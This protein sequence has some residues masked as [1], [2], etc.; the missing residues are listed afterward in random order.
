MQKYSLQFEKPAVLEVLTHDNRYTKVFDVLKSYRMLQQAEKEPTPDAM[1]G[2]I[3]N[4]LKTSLGLQSNEDLA[5]GMA[6]EFR[7]AIIGIYVNLSE[8]VKKKLQKIV[9]SPLSF[10][11]SQATIP[12]GPTS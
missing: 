10:P 6:Y 11:E 1:W 7:E 8:T 9:S 12:N 2:M 4:Y 5:E 3:E